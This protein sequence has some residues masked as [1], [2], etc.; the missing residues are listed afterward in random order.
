VTC[1]INYLPVE[2]LANVSYQRDVG[3]RTEIGIK[4]LQQIC[5]NSM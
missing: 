3:E 1:D 5:E 2:L 4:L